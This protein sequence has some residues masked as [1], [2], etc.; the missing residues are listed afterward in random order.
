MKIIKTLITFTFLGMFF[1]HGLHAQKGSLNIGASFLWN[2]ARIADPI[3]YEDNNPLF[4]FSTMVK[5]EFEPLKNLRVSYGIGNIVKGYTSS[6]T[7]RGS[8]GV[9]ESVKVENKLTYLTN[10]LAVGWTIGSKFRIIPEIGFSFDVLINQEKTIGAFENLEEQKINTPEYF[11]DLSACVFGG[12]SFRY[13]L[14]NRMDLGVLAKYSQG[15]NEITPKGSLVPEGKPSN[16]LVGAEIVWH[17]KKDK[18]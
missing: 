16:F 4:G 8:D 17:L 15:L 1:A 3:L 12:V 9:Y 7:F 11:A 13:P 18:E 14:F 5:L 10:Q 2:K 6:V